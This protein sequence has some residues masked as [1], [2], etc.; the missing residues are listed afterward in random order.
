[1]KAV[2]DTCS[3]ISFVRYYLP[4]DQGNRLKDFLKEQILDKKIIVLDKVA[5]ECEYTSNGLV[6]K[7][8][9]FIKDKKY[10]TSTSSLVAPPKFHHLIDCNFINASEK[11]KL[12]DAEY[13]KLR[14][15]YLNSADCSLIL[16]TYDKKNTEEI[17]IITEETGYNNDGKAFKKIPENCKAIDIK[18][19]MLPEFLKSNGIINLSIDI[20]ATSLF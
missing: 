15:D 3:L 4:F 16:Y 8:L 12:T 14:G 11:R 6:V 1:M 13:Q 19:Q 17:V 20:A 9:P 5:A 7:S 2:I 10:R 18:T